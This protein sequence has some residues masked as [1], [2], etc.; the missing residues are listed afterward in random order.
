MTWTFDSI[1]SEVSMRSVAP[2]ISQARDLL[3]DVLG[4]AFY[5]LE[6]G[7]L[8]YFVETIKL[9]RSGGIFGFSRLKSPGNCTKISGSKLCVSYR[10]IYRFSRKKRCNILIWCSRTSVKSL[11]NPCTPTRITNKT[12]Q[13]GN[14]RNSGITNCHHLVGNWSQNKRSSRLEWQPPLHIMQSRATAIIVDLHLLFRRPPLPP[15][16]TWLLGVDYAQ[17]PLED[18]VKMISRELGM[19]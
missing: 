17:P 18:N 12:R 8:S 5:I 10:Q 16:R 11:N 4:S 6:N 9:I 15:A 13:L 19:I 3:S 1:P 7:L 14:S 2:S